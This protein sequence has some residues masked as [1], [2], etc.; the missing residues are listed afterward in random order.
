MILRVIR[1]CGYYIISRCLP[2]N[3][4]VHNSSLIDAVCIFVFT[5]WITAVDILILFSVDYQK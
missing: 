2:C 4:D 5:I 1:V 3:D